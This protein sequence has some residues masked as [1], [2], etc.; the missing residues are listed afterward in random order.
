[1]SELESKIENALYREILTYDG[2]R[3]IV[4]DRSNDRLYYKKTLTVYCAPVFSWLKEHPHPALPRI[5]AFWQTA[6]ALVVIE[7]L[8]Q[9]QTLE[10]L[11]SENALPA[12]EKRKILLAVCDALIF[13]HHADPPIVYRDLKASSIILTESGAVK[14]IGFD[15]A[16]VCGSTAAGPAPELIGTPGIAAPEQYGFGQ[17]DARTDIYALGKLIARMLPPTRRIRRIVRKATRLDPGKRY[18]SVEE[19]RRQIKII[20]V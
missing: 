15:A 4:L 5:R 10:D 3:S 6:G 1:M 7:E 11:L 18:A 16:V 19:I 2:A 8:V 17:P 13:L 12:D 9:G 14:L 20:K